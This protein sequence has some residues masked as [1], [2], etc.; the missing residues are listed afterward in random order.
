MF[1]RFDRF[2]R[3]CVLCGFDRLRILQLRAPNVIPEATCHAESIS[4]LL[5]SFQYT[6]VD[7]GGG[8]GGGGGARY[9]PKLEILVVMGQMVFF[10]FADVTG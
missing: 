1:S 7:R 6:K 4:L 5:A 8:G 3:S 9:V 2:S 10:K